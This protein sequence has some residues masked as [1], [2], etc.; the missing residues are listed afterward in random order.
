MKI[1]GFFG[2]GGTGKTT[3]AALFLREL[4]K[5]GEGRI[6]AVD[7]DP[8]E[9]LACL[10]GVEG[11]SSIADMINDYHQQRNKS[12]ELTG[13]EIFQNFFDSLIMEG[14]Q[15]GYDMLVMGRGEG[16]GCYCAVNDLLKAVFRKTIDDDYYK[17]LLMDCEA[18]LEHIARKTSSKIHDV[19]IV[20]DASR[21]SLDTLKRIKEVATEVKAEIENY[22]VVANRVRPKMQNKVKEAAESLGFTYLG[23]IPD[24]PQFEEMAYEGKTVF[25]LPED[26]QVVQAVKKMVDQYLA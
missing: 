9:C 5:R 7:A 14:E 19:I 6:L 13:V 1:V 21:V 24:D 25:D 16:E 3:L 22:Y 17:F 2:K 18:G 11:L 23:A 8:N 26:S 12:P 4:I 10:M 20:T 15:E